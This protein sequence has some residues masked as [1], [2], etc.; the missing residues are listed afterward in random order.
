MTNESVSAKSQT[1][2]P[3]PQWKAI[4]ARYQQP[5][6]LR[7]LWQLANTLIPYAVLWYL[8]YLS[9]S[10]SFWLTAGL[11]LLAA[12]FLVRMFIIFHDC[13]HGSFLI[14]PGE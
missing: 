1:A 4:V 10:I 5:A 8:M 3:A 2:T 14:P 7:G 12:G 13:G 6:L 9:L 11:A